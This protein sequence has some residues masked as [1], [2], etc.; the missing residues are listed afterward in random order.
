MRRSRRRGREVEHTSHERWMV[1]YA[2]FITVLFALFVVLFASAYQDNQSVRKLSQAIHSGFQQLGPF[3]G[4]LPPNSLTPSPLPPDSIAQPPPPKKPTV[5]VDTEQLRRELD[6]AIGEEMKNKEVVTRDT[7]EGFV[8]SL[9]ELGFFSSGHAD[10]RPGAAQKIEKIARVLAQHGFELRVE[11]HS[12]NQPIHNAQFSSNWQL[13]TARATAVLLHLVDDSG[14]DPAK[15]SVAGY[16][17]FRPL[18]DNST[19]EGRRMN[20][21][22]DLVVVAAA[23]GAAA[24]PAAPAAAPPPTTSVPVTP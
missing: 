19:P 14:L 22:I 11:G 20:R 24:P 23:P 10:L 6:A 15:I 1:S 3:T 2:D 16:G 5:G 9:K 18:A 8:I 4:S 7:P 12:D 13:S 17:E 21:R